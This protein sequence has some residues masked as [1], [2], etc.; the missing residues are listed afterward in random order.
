MSSIGSAAPSV[1]D[2][3]L[4]ISPASTTLNSFDPL[5]ERMTSP[6][7][8]EPIPLDV[9]FSPAC[10]WLQRSA[11]LWQQLLPGFFRPGFLIRPWPN[12]T[13]RVVTRLLLAGV[14]VRLSRPQAGGA[15]GITPYGLFLLRGADQPGL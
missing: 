15:S 8:C 4:E 3:N 5:T 13:R 14:Q 1:D 12:Q 2:R 7:G 6:A 10:W 9:D 11:A